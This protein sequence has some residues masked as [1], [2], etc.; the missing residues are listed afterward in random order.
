MHVSFIHT[1]Y[2]HKYIYSAYTLR[3]PATSTLPYK[4]FGIH[5]SRNMGVGYV[6]SPFVYPVFTIAMALNHSWFPKRSIYSDVRVHLIYTF[7]AMCIH[8]QCFLKGCA[9]RRGVTTYKYICIW[10]FGPSGF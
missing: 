6:D 5:Q 8:L 4:T 9:C 3:M 1:S 2:I 10:A 7:M